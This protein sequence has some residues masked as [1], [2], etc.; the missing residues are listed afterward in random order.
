MSYEK[1]GIESLEVARLC[2]EETNYNSCVNRYYY[3]FYQKLM[4]KLTSKGIS[5]NEEHLSGGSHEKAF[6]QFIDEVLRP[7]KRPK[8]RVRALKKCLLFL[9]KLHGK[10]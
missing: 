4:N 8:Q 1:K 5:I 7:I 6:N 10:K 2:Y 3:S 9:P